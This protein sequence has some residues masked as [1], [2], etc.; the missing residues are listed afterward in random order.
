MLN[1]E[2]T[3]L[4]ALMLETGLLQ[5]GSFDHNHASVPF[6]LNL[7]WLPAYPDVLRAIVSAA[8]PMIDWQIID[9]LVATPD[10]VPFGVA[11][12][13]AT[14][15]SLVYSRGLR[16][17]PALDLVGAY[18]IGHTSL[19]L[20]NTIS[21]NYPLQPI[22]AAATQVGLEIQNVLAI[23]DQ[24]TGSNLKGVQTQTLLSLPDVIQAMLVSGQIPKLQTQVV[25]NWIDR[26]TTAD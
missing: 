4:I 1:Q 9:R 11:L 25:L 22:I 13:L 24:G 26:Q 23:V 2:S 5:F 10:A 8:Q 3:R 14:D 7:Q 16:V 17:G 18:D 21:A 12:S 20:T 19:L 15:I 6:Q